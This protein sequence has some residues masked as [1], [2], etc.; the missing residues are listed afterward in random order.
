MDANTN[1]I[2]FA[3]ACAAAFIAFFLFVASQH[4]DAFCRR[5]SRLSENILV[6]VPGRLG[7]AA[8]RRRACR[9]EVIGA[10]SKLTNLCAEFHN[11][12]FVRVMNNDYD[13]ADFTDDVRQDWPDFSARL[14]ESIYELA[15]AFEHA[16]IDNPGEELN[17]CLD[18]ADRT[19]DTICR[20]D[21]VVCRRFGL[22]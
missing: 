3:A 15:Q 2:L 19:A 17:A 16:A 5:F 20:G 21:A 13:D 6:L 10:M 11:G 9:E 18:W 7:S 12:W 4:F 22:M 14:S 1:S 8:R